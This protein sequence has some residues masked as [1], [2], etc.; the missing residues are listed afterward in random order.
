MI[1]PLAIGIKIL[2]IA[3]LATSCNSQTKR[4]VTAADNSAPLRLAPFSADTARAYIA[5]QLAFGPR[6]PGTKAHQ[7]C[8]NF[9]AATLDSLG[10]DTVISQYA[11]LRYPDGSPMPMRNIMARFN[12]SQPHRILLAA[13]WDTRPWA[14]NDPD[15]TN[16]DKPLPGANDGASGVAVLLEIAR[17]ITQNTPEAGV[18]IL[19]LDCEDAGNHSDDSSWGLGAQYFAQNL[20]YT[21][22][23]IPAY[24]I[25]LDMV[26]DP[27]ARFYR[28][29]V[30]QRYARQVN[31]RIH[32]IARMSGFDNYFIDEIGGAVTDDHT[33]L[34]RAGIPTADIID[35]TN[36][37]TGSFPRSWHTMADDLNAISTETLHAVG[38]TVANIIYSEHIQSES[39]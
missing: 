12:I 16:H 20:P 13:H 34:N 25:L 15:P 38:Q 21:S 32:D 5:A 37:L 9:L 2:I 11:T 10:A 35:C 23:D 17:L 8:G 3:L 26:G 4:N 1:R 18:D 27:A 24:G 33:F 14:D 19:L 39:K 28:E 31:D 29:Y 36:A 6:V 30:S 22:H 7:D